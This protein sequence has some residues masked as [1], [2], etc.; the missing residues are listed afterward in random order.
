MGVVFDE[1]VSQVEGPPEQPQA[2]RQTGE[3]ELSPQEKLRCWRRQQAIADR[4]RRR[5]EAD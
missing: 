1:V 2:E 4:R 5:L 3:Q